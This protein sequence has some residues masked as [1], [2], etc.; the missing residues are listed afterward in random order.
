M[1]TIQQ[2]LL[3]EIHYPIPLGFV[4]NVLIKR[5]LNGED[6]FDYNTS[7]SIS[8]KGAF[9]DC[10]ISLVQAVSVSEAGK[11]IGAPSDSDKRRLLRMANSLYQSIG[12]PMAEIE[13]R[14]TVYIG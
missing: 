8:Y 1:K 9:A 10:L 6:E 4:E 5:N 12:E 14:P 3:D 7:N 13:L 11:S 2:A